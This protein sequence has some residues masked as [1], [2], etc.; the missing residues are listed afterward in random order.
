M[1]TPRGDKLL[2][3]MKKL[4]GPIARLFSKIGQ[5]KGGAMEATEEET[6]T[7]KSKEDDETT[8]D[9]LQPFPHKHST[10][11][12]ESEEH[13]NTVLRTI[14]DGDIGFDTEF[15]DRRPTKEEKMIEARFPK[16]SAARKAVILGWQVV[17]LGIHRV[18]PVAWNNIGL[19]T[20]QVARDDKVWVLD[21]W[22]IKAVPKELK[23]ILESP[24]V[25]KTGGGLTRDIL[26][27]WDDLRIEMLNLVDV[28]MMAKLVLAEKY[29]KMAY[30]NLVLRTS[31]QDILGF[32]MSKD[33]A[34]SDWSVATLTDAQTDYAALDAVAS[35]RLFEVLE[36][37]LARKS[38]TIG[39]SIPDAWYRFNSRSGEP[40]RRRLAA[41]GSE[42]LWRTS[43]CTWYAGGK[44]QGYP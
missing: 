8:V 11:L 24:Q 31:V 5:D 1:P 25:K 2:A 36:D 28:G 12:V 33:L 40:T 38:H 23:R 7:A 16:G 6:P 44:F 29:P 4:V 21:M 20:V 9:G 32:E 30:G 26:V 35:L 10:I 18:F 41:D 15:T 34:T 19:R 3:S 39:Q 22:K 14:L 37:A 27:I 42:I 43:D 17:E 13:A